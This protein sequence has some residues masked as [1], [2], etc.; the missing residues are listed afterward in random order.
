MKRTISSKPERFFALHLSPGLAEYKSPKGE[1]FKVLVEREAAIDMDQTFEGCPAF[2]FHKD[3]VDIDKPNMDELD[4][5]VSKSFYNKWD[6]NHWVE[7]IAITDQA[8]EAIKIKG[9]K[10]SNCSITD[11][12]GPAGR[13]QGSE[14]RHS[15]KRGHYEHLAIVPNPRYTQS[16]V[17]TP[18]EF[19][20]YNATLEEKLTRLNNSDEDETEH[21]QQKD[22][23]MK[24]PFSFFTT[25]VK[26][27]ENSDDIA[28]MSVVLPSSKKTVSVA[29][30]LKAA[31]D[32]EVLRLENAGKTSY[33]NDDD[34]VKLENGEEMS[35]KDCKKAMNAANKKKN[36]DAEKELEDDL[37][38]A[39]DEDK[40]K[41]KNKNSKSKNADDV[42]DEELRLKN[43]DELTLE[44]AKRKLVLITQ[45]VKNENFSRLKNAQT[46]AKQKQD[47]V[48]I[49][50]TQAAVQAG[51]Q[52]YGSAK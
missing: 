48:S 2:V 39:D 28:K 18:E 31:D 12:A 10:V 51:A 11:E 50:T 16:I 19:R 7:F 17:L 36:E 26:K 23:N 35:I 9:W 37:E 44:E 5:L 3:E 27:L 32:S 8:K 46:N 4:G 25:E 52:K 34:K 33:A 20:D 15:I 41:E 47:G 21:D 49:V 38:N 43:D 6:G 22:E 13:W 29:D 24:N 14:Y 45:D 42:S 1:P 30:V 40:D